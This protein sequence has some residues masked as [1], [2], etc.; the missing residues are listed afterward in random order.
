MDGDA[1]RTGTGSV[2]LASVTQPGYLKV[3]IGVRVDMT[4]SRADRVETNRAP[5]VVIRHKP[6]KPLL[7]PP[8]EQAELS[9]GT[10][11]KVIF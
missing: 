2:L 9:T 3:Y 6:D 10:E 8:P 4:D 11:W 5:S 1:G 7:T